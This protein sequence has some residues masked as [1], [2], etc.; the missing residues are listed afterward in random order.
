MSFRTEG[1]YSG[2]WLKEEVGRRS[3]EEVTILAGSGATR[4]LTSG[5]VLGKITND[6]TAVAA[7]VAGNAGNGTVGIITESAGVKAGVYRVTFVEGATD[8]GDFIVEDPAGINLGPGV[9]GTA[10]T[11]GGLS[12]TIADGSNDFAGGDQFT[13]TVG[14]GSLK[15][16][17]FDQDAADGSQN[18]AGVL[19]D[20]KTAPDGADAVGVAIVRDAIVNQNQLV[21][22][23]DIDSGEQTAAEAQLEAL[24]ILVREGA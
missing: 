9:V 15:W 7:A 8:L 16:V 24:G 11:G 6:L 18:A 12:F 19:L 3:R 22:P 2:D 23:S 10:F 1:K 5:M 4:P 21:W 17:Q 14:V 13:I 20:D